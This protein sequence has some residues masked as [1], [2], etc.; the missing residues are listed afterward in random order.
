MEIVFG[1]NG[2]S[3]VKI[4]PMELSQGNIHVAYCK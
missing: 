3:V 1:M 2:L 4:L